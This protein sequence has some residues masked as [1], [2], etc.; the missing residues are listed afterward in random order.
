MITDQ[1]RLSW[2]F[3]PACLSKILNFSRG[4]IRFHFIHKLISEHVLLFCHRELA[5]HW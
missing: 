3:D 4:H 2:E 5:R 1:I